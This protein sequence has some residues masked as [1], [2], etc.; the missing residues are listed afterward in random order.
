MAVSGTAKGQ[1][2]KLRA[3]G[4]MLAGLDKS[5]PSLSLKFPVSTR[6]RVSLMRS[7]ALSCWHILSTRVLRKKAL[8]EA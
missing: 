5:F 1:V 8:N 6:E 2:P 7:E 3:R 4:L